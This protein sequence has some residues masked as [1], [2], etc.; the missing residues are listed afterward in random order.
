MESWTGLIQSFGEK[1]KLYNKLVDT[2]YYSL[3][4]TYRLLSTFK[5]TCSF[6]VSQGI[7]TRCKC[8]KSFRESL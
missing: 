2:Y 1:M 7:N 6:P 8:G 3:F 5:H 4:Y